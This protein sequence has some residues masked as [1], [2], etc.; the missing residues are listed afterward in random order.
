M[1]VS[2][3]GLAMDPEKRLRRAKRPRCRVPASHRLMRLHFSFASLFRFPS[4]SFGQIYSPSRSSVTDTRPKWVL[5]HTYPFLPIQND[6]RGGRRSDGRDRPPHRS[7]QP[8]QEQASTAV[9]DQ[10]HGWMERQGRLIPQVFLS[11]PIPIFRNPI[12][13]ACAYQ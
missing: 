13:S 10:R 2:Y 8:V 11:N 7:D 9:C 12:A 1:S 6:G 3:D 5:H 4:I